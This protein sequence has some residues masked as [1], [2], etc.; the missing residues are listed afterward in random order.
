[1]M[2]QELK[3]TYNFRRKCIPGE[4]SAQVRIRSHKDFS[5]A[6]SMEMHL[7][8]SPFIFLFLLD[9]FCHRDHLE[10]LHDHFICLS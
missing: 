3:L 1:M 9:P 8:E 5:F 4:I 7:L 6:S 2:C 10:G